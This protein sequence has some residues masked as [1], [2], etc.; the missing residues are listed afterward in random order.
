[1]KLILAL[2]TLLL[3]VTTVAEAKKSKKAT[4][5]DTPPKSSTA[6]GSPIVF[7]TIHVRDIKRSQEFY[8]KMFDWKFEKGPSDT[9][10][11]INTGSIRGTFV[12]HKDFTTGLSSEIYVLVKD[13]NKAYAQALKLGASKVT[14]TEMAPQAAP[15][16]DG[17]FAQVNDPDGNRIGLSEAKK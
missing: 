6:S 11:F 17:R 1:M 2:A 16:D 3:A 8:S 12:Q 5:E 14:P 13:V 10:S 4:V 15:N 7:F 9:I